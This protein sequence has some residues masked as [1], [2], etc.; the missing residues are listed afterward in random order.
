MKRMR[1][2]LVHISKIG[3][4]NPYQRLQQIH[5]Q[6]IQRGE[7]NN[8]KSFN[9][10]LPPLN[11][12][13]IPNTARIRRNQLSLSSN[14]QKL[15]K[16]EVNDQNNNDNVIDN[17]ATVDTKKENQVQMPVTG[18]YALNNL[19]DLLLE[20]EKKEIE[21]YQDVY[22]IRQE[23]PEPRPFPQKIPNFFPFVQNDHIAYR[24]QQLEQMGK[25]AFGSVIK[26]FDHKN[27]R[28]VAVKMIRDQ[29]K[30]HDQTRLERDILKTMQ[31][32]NRVVRFLKSFTF[33]GFFCIVTELLYKDCY[34]ILKRQ[35]Y[36]GFNLTTL[37]M[38][39]KQLAE[40]IG[41]AHKK[42]IIHCDIKPENVMFTSK[43]K[44]GVKLVDY[45]CSCYEDKILFSY[46][47][48]R[49]FRAPEVALGIQYGTEIDVWSYACVLVELFTGKPLFP[50]NDERELLEMF[51]TYFGNPP[52][53]LIIG[54]KRA[55][56]FFDSEGNMKEN[57]EKY[58][59]HKGQKT[60]KISPSSLKIEDLFN[61]KTNDDDEEEDEESNVNEGVKQLCDLVKKCFC[62]LPKDRITMAEILDHPFITNPDIK[63]QEP[64]LPALSAR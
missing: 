42:N 32:C 11:L 45:G 17:D 5:Q 33:R 39:A 47:Q 35:R 26:C 52:P 15:N 28:R 12:N 49:Y 7:L 43:R 16:D 29:L 9:V 21:N 40:A 38:I 46:I 59:I 3:I 60:E 41:F 34:T 51:V 6:Q 2:A 14:A 13:T 36:Y 56:K 62:W 25:G 63:N 1:P 31:G 27:G 23:K 10:Q 30:Y 22:Y 55:E 48:S 24:Y 57:K 64:N 37:Q 44:I 8:K 20:F 50:A 58:T 19:S 54:K 18:E 4:S 53:E 61:I